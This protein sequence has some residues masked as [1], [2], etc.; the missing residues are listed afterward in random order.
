M[1]NY[2]QTNPASH[3]VQKSICSLPTANGRISL[4]G[5]QMKITQDGTI[6]EKTLTDDDMIN[7]LW[8]YFG[9]KM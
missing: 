5:N 6:S 1:C 9:I 7:A 2:H 8:N 4:S 3:F